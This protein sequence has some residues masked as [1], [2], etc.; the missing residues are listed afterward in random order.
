MFSLSNFLSKSRE[1]VCYLV[2]LGWDIMK[3]KC[4]THEL[5]YHISYP[6][7]LYVSEWFVENALE[8]TTVGVDMDEWG[9]IKVVKGCVTSKFKC[10]YLCIH[11]RILFL[12]ISQSRTVSLDNTYIFSLFQVV[13]I[14]EEDKSHARAV[15]AICGYVD[16]HLYIKR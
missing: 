7:V 11:S 4:E 10:K 9:S 3:F 1:A 2:L 12:T 14:L 8:T 15:S 13:C 5:L 16:S 6:S